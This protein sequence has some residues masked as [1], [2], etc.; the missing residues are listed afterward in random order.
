AK[1][2]QLE[3]ITSMGKSIAEDKKKTLGDI[4]ELKVN[5]SSLQSD[6]VTKEKVIA[7][8]T[9]KLNSLREAVK[10]ARQDSRYIAKL[11][12]QEA[13]KA[14]IKKL[15]EN[16]NEAVADLEQQNSELRSKRS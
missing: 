9:D 7:G 2:A 4:E 3:H 6:I 11:Q 15:Q 5:V 13:I 14:E 1:S 8:L 12:E 16:A 10:D